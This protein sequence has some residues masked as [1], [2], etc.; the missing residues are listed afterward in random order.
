[1]PENK[2]N[3]LLAVTSGHGHVWLCPC[4]SRIAGKHDR[5]I[6][7]TSCLPTSWRRPWSTFKSMDPMTIFV[8][9]SFRDGT[10][11]ADINAALWTSLFL[12]NKEPR[13]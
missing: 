3:H 9:G 1:M 6:A 7:Y 2:E 8:A 12:T 4:R 13:T 11:V 5:F 10:R